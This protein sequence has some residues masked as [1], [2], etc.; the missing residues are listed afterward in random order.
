MRYGDAT[1]N[2]LKDTKLVAI[3]PMPPLP[4]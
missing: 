3:A 4:C 2:N 1:I